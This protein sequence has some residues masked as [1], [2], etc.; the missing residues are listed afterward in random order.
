M[1]ERIG[2]SGGMERET[3]TETA[4]SGEDKRGGVSVS[5]AGLSSRKGMRI[6]RLISLSN[7]FLP[8]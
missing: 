2:R 7:P 6:K 5:R 4:T 8:D 3:E 1:R